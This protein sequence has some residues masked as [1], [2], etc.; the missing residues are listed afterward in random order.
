MT[1]PSDREHLLHDLRQPLSAILAA[2]TALR[3]NPSIDETTSEQLLTII[4]NNAERLSEMLGE[5]LPD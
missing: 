1:A 4:V 3:A 2:A 5:S